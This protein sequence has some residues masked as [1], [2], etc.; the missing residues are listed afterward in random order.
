KPDCL[1]DIIA[2]VSLFRPGPID[3]I[4][5]YCRNKH[6]PA[7]TTYDHEKL[8]PI[9][10]NT[11]GI[12]VYQEQV[13]SIFREIA[14]YTLGQADMVR[15]IMGKKKPKEMD[16]HR[17]VFV[18]G[19]KKMN[20]KGAV[21][22]GVDRKTAL[23]IYEKMAKFAEYAFNKS[24]AACYSFLAY[25]TA[26][27]KYNY[28]G[29]YMASV[30]NNRI[31]KSD[32]ITK[33]MQSIKA[34]GMAVLPPDINKSGAYFGVESQ[35]AIR[36]GLAGLKGVGLGVIER[37]LEERANCGNFKSFEDFINRVSS[38]ILNKRVLESFILGGAFDGFGI[39]RSVLI[40]SYEQLVERVIKDKKTRENGQ[41]S[42]FDFLG[43]SS[44]SGVAYEYPKINEYD[45]IKKLQLE[46]D[47]IGI[48]I[49]GHP[50]EEFAGVFSGC[51]F[52]TSMI[53]R[54]KDDEAEAEYAIED[55]EEEI[56]LPEGSFVSFGGIIT[57]VRR[58]AAKN[59]A[60]LKV[61]DLYG[62]CDVVLFSNTV[63]K[64]KNL[65][66]TDNI[67]LIKG[68]TSN[69]QGFD[70]SIMCSDIKL[71]EKNAIEGEKRPN[72]SKLSLRYDTLDLELHKTV[73]K[74]LEAY[75]GESGCFIR[76]TQ[77]G[78]AFDSGFKVN[79]CKALVWEIMSIIGKENIV[80][81]GLDL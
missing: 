81:E 40:A 50:L 37:I 70:T 44:S 76:C 29:Q 56:G 2:A 41:F 60:I 24:H 31:T 15:R 74:V 32:E 16:F 65:L 68:R 27:L 1:E 80:T 55:E 9:L 46:K 73:C 3:M 66:N 11:Y 18:D 10:K 39:A 14:G 21:A 62:S 13:Q 52:N 22:N 42:M 59:M 49:S 33:Y 38:D 54:A 51:N 67:V 63:D 53:R 20:I 8:K 30:L 48:Y 75:G 17:H 45:K 78:K 34:R 5:D 6:N 26:Y 71:I 58:I 4:P 69:R 19:D 12:I 36:F 7:L 25:Q 43:S 72:N 57:D 61:E 35:K 77:S 28:Y 79:L 23:N 47:V 64:F